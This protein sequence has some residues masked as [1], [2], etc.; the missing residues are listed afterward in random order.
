M[1]FTRDSAALV[2]VRAISSSVGLSYR[3]D[4]P[5]SDSPLPLVDESWASDQH[6]R[7]GETAARAC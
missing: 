7:L 2:I 5:G 4:A 3:S 6:P 1:P